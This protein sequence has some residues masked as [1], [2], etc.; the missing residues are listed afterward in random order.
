MSTYTELSQE[1]AK[2]IAVK[3]DL[4][5]ELIEPVR[6]WSASDDGFDRTGFLA[7]LYSNNDV[8]IYPLWGDLDKLDED[9]KYDLPDVYNDCP[10]LDWFVSAKLEDHGEPELVGPDGA[11]LP[12]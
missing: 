9:F 2:A 12:W 5:S 10:S 11:R 1:Q 4:H 7:V 6:L 8:V 3:L